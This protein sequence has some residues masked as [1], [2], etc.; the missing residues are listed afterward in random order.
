MSAGGWDQV[1]DGVFRRRYRSLD[2]NIGAVLGGN[3][4]LLVDTRSHQDEAAELRR[5]LEA[6]TALPCRQVVNTHA[7]FDH[8]FGNATLRPAAIWGHPHCA[9]A[10]RGRGEEVRASA[11]RW[12]PE[13]A[14]RLARLEIVPPDRLVADRT[15]LDLGGRRVDLVHLGRGHTDNDLVVLVPDA[16]VAFAG[17]LV[18]EGAPPSFG[19]AWPLE[20]P[21]T[22]DRLLAPAPSV[23][24]PGHGDVVDQAFVREQRDQ[25]AAMAELCRRVVEERLPAEEAVRLAPFPATTART[26]IERAVETVASEV[27]PEEHL[28]TILVEEDA[29]ARIRD[30]DQVTG[31][32]ANPPIEPFGPPS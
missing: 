3:Q 19:D 27:D 23:V 2:L 4:V 29:A 12:L 20:W 13:A 22:L 31:V 21:G 8:C 28:S 18:E 32:H 17:D 30:A 1:G 26:A 15:A 6:L 11:V 16:G 25:Q 14:E 24:V 10:L 5:D 7:H 9:E